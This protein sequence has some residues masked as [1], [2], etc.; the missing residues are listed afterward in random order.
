MNSISANT[1][2]K[3]NSGKATAAGPAEGAGW[4]VAV[5]VG[6]GVGGACRVGVGWAVAADPQA[7]AST[8]KAAGAAVTNN[9]FSLRLN[10]DSYFTRKVPESKI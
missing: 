9:D 5:A 2:S 1:L 8:R 3:L 10:I 6:I 4:D 7:N